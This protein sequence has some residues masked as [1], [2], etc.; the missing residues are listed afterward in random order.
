MITVLLWV[1]I[2]VGAPAA[3]PSTTPTQSTEVTVPAPRVEP[4]SAS[5]RAA[6]TGVSWHEGCPVSLDELRRVHVRY[7]GPDG[8]EHDGE[9]IIHK[10]DAQAIAQVFDTLLAQRFVIDKVAAAYTYRGDD[11]AMM[12]DNVTSAFNC[13]M[14]AGTKVYSEHSTGKALDLNPLWNPWVHDDK[15]D[16]PA[17]RAF[18]ERDPDRPGTLVAGCDAVAAFRQ[19]GWHWGGNWKRS[20]DYQHFSRSGR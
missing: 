13:R 17:A 4:L 18:A 3:Q 7:L 14:V 5:V 10:D 8:S 12:N 19:I 15:V 9:L 2:V 16:P 6:M 1:P 11:D 20:Q